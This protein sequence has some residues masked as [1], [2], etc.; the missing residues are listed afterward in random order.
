[1]A[2]RNIILIAE[3]ERVESIILNDLFKSDYRLMMCSSHEDAVR[4]FEAFRRQICCVIYSDRRPALDCEMFCDF[5]YNK[6]YMNDTP[7]IILSDSISIDVNSDVYFDLYDMGVSEIVSIPFDSYYLKMRVKKYE[8]D[9]NNVVEAK[10]EAERYRIHAEERTN[11]VI[12][13]IGSVFELIQFE[14]PTH[15]RRMKHLT[16][17]IASRYIEKFPECGLTAKD[18][19]Y[20]SA[21]AEVHDLGKAAIPTNI[22]F[23]PGKL[24]PEEFDL[25]KTHTERGIEIFKDFGITDDHPFFRYCFDISMY[26]HERW[27]GRGYPKRLKEDEIPLAAQIVS[28]V[29]VYDALVSERVYKSAIPYEKAVGMIKNGECGL[30]PPKVVETFN[31]VEDDFRKYTNMVLSTNF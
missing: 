31:E 13:I 14:P 4:K 17:I 7:L 24:T 26:H 20:I 6:G 19:E 18:V 5:F 28:I 25:M 9:A 29:D 16:N 3:N 27:D 2:R 15:V 12:T 1:M 8:N 11:S 21:A 23:K 30:F 10:G 22:L